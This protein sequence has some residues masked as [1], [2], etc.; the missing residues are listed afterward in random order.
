MKI[1]TNNETF[2]GYVEI[3]DDFGWPE[4]L[5]YYGIMRATKGKEPEE[6]F[7]YM[8]PGLIKIVKAWH[9]EGWPEKPKK[10][11]DIP[12]KPFTEVVK[13]LGVLF[14]AVQK[15]ALDDLTVPLPQ[16]ETPIKP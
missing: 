13:V 4:T 12:C 2:P 15:E 10:A 7:Y 11:E 14:R 3:P 5:A 1:D 9:I 8:I 6:S 16:S